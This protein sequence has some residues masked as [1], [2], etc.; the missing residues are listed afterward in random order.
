MRRILLFLAGLL[1]GL[2]AEAILWTGPGVYTNVAQYYAALTYIALRSAVLGLIVQGAMAAAVAA[3]WLAR[4]SAPARLL[5]QGGSTRE[6][7]SS[8]TACDGAFLPI[9]GILLLLAAG[10]PFGQALRDMETLHDWE[11]V[12]F[13]TSQEIKDSVHE[14]LQ[15]G[16]AFAAVYV[17][18]GATLLVGSRFARSRGLP[19][20]RRIDGVGCGI[21]MSSLL[22]T[23]VGILLELANAMTMEGHS[24]SVTL[25]ASLIVLGGT[26]LAM[27]GM[28]VA[29][30]GR[31]R[32]GLD[33]AELSRT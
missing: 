17:V 5:A 24:E 19:R 32:R 10:G 26:L 28:V 31:Q 3:C 2:V 12:D 22:L 9:W 8:L 1:V 20:N 14:S 27:I 23:G 18:A 29:V 16:A 15:I 30:R 7:P 33:K 11:L 6:P 21:A 4:A 25:V 13:R